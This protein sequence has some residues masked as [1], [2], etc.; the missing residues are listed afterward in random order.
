MFVH[1]LLLE[2]LIVG[3]AGDDVIQEYDYSEVYAPLDLN[4]GHCRLSVAA[5][6]LNYLKKDDQ[7]ET[8]SNIRVATKYPNII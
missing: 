2:Q 6:M 4:I 3:I 7:L 5:P 1:L 8:W